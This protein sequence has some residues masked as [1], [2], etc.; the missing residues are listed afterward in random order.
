[1]RLRLN[2]CLFGFGGIASLCFQTEL[3]ICLDTLTVSCLTRP[4]HILEKTFSLGTQ[5][6]FLY[7]PGCLYMSSVVDAERVPPAPRLSL[8]FYDLPY[9]EIAIAIEDL[10]TLFSLPKPPIS[11]S[12]VEKNIA[13]RQRRQNQEKI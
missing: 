13:G 9:L 2:K 10:S 7:Q 8:S 5:P 4:T 6:G 3:V 1:M 11:S 12:F